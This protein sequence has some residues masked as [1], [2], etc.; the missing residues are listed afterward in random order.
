MADKILIVDDD[1]DTLKLVGLML[2][3][4][5][6][7]IVVA[8]NGKLGI[9]KASEEKPDL[10][11]LD[12]MMPDLDGYQVTRRLR[13]DPALAHIPIIMFTAKSMV[14][15]KVAGFEAGVDDY[16]TKPTHP[17][18]L[19]AHVK[20][21]LART[22]Q[23]TTE[24]GDRAS[25]IGFIGCRSGIGTTTLAVNVSIVLHEKHENTILAELNP[26][27]GTLGLD[28]NV[29]NPKGLTNLLSRSLKDLN[30]KA[31]ESELIKHELGP[32][33]LM[34][35]YHPSEE[36]MEQAV[37]QMEAV[38]NNLTA[39]ADILVL[40]LGAGL[41]PYAK[42][43]AQLCDRLV[44]VV[45]PV[46]PSNIIGRSM[47]EDLEMA[48]IG[49]HRIKLAL[50]NRVRTS[51]QIPWRQVETDLGIELVGIVS[52]AAEQAHQ[53]SQDGVPLVRCHPDTLVA[54]QMRKMAESIASQLQPIES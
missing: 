24:P 53:A 4:Q 32:K 44:L 2:E 22:V 31:V 20:A 14:D 34:A 52:P 9:A 18:E 11:L 40:D 17:A 7:N 45:E 26:G 50:V 28:L 1:I 36:E 6:Y 38:V 35:S 5:G 46:Y 15:D 39:L 49:R 16:L 51:L 3:R 41:R 33:F 47:L 21:V 12:V 8:S 30:P 10:I 29:P 19:T 13:S 25:T 37:P 48:G 42:P 27:R 43:I 54:D 23:A